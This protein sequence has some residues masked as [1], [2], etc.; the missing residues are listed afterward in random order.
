MLAC[1]RCQT[2]VGIP[3]TGKTV[4]MEMEGPFQVWKP[5][6]TRA[7]SSLPIKPIVALY[8]CQLCSVTIYDLSVVWWTWC[9]RVGGRAGESWVSQGIM[10]NSASILRH[11][12]AIRWSEMNGSGSQMAKA[13][14]HRDWKWGNDHRIWS[15]CNSP[16]WGET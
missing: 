8:G 13:L 11:H 3:G 14:P 2:C 6:L 10:P 12:W 5:W 9:L 15:V 1:C 7:E 4:H 16:R